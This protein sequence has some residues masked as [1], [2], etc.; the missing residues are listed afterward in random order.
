MPNVNEYAPGTPC[1]FELGTTDQSAA[2]EFYGKLFGWSANDMPMGPDGVYTIFQLN[3]RDVGA[4]WTLPQKLRD[5]GVPP[6]WGVYFAVPDVDAAAPRVTEL[7]GTLLQPP[8]DVMDAGRMAVA[9]DPGGAVFSLW[10]A[11]KNIGAGVLNENGAVC[12]AELATRDTAQ[13]REFYSRLLG[14]ETKSSAN[15]ATYIEFSTGGQER[16]GLLPMGPE[17]KDAPSHWG[18]YIHVPDCD[19]AS[20]RA[21]ELGGAM[22]VG[23]FSAPGVGRIA[24]LTDPQGAAFSMIKLDAM[25]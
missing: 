9:K 16:G 4:L 5:Q 24:I 13:A 19:A 8:F 21:K 11:K 10:Q 1:W 2:K 6:H 20:A 22:C 18:I 12:W 25:N 15:M 14:W 7:G 17:W 23:P 3:G